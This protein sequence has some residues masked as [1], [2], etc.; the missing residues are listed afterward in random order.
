VRS[1][2]LLAWL[3]ITPLQRRP[4][5]YK[6]YGSRAA[7]ALT[8][9]MLQGIAPTA[10][11]CR[12]YPPRRSTK[13]P[14]RVPWTITVRSGPEARSHQSGGRAL[15]STATHPGC[16]GRGHHGGLR[17]RRGTGCDGGGHHGGFRDWR[18]DDTDSANTRW[19]EWHLSV[20][21]GCSCLVGLDRGDDRL[22]GN[23]PVGDQLAA[24]MPHR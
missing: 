17:D 24:R 13:R 16:D 3:V 7:R 4:A 10:L 1:T 22:D 23:P 8:A 14:T 11:L 2:A 6:K 20:S 12:D 19:S 9:P 18:A 21:Y 5:A 15:Y